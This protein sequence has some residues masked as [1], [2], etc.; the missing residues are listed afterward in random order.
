MS[1]AVH[2]LLVDDERPIL[3]SLQRVFADTE[4]EIH[5]ADSGAAALKLLAEQRVDLILSDMRMPEM[6]GHQFLRQVKEL[7]PQTLRIILSG[8][9]D[10][11]VI[12]RS[13]LDGSAKLYLL[14]PWDNERLLQVV[15]NMLKMRDL[16]RERR[17]LELV[18]GIDTL[19]IVAQTYLAVRRLIDENAEMKEIA[20]EIERDPAMAARVLSLAN[21]AFNGVNTGSV[22]QAI[23]YMGLSVVKELL[24]STSVLAEAPQRGPGFDGKLFCRHAAYANRFVEQIFRRKLAKKLP[25][26]V[27]CAALLCD[28]GTIF[29]T[30]N[31][32]VPYGEAIQRAAGDENLTL[33]QAERELIGVSH[34][35][36]GAYLLE[37]WGLPFSMVEVAMYHHQPQAASEV[38]REVV[39][40]VHV[41]DCL[42]W[43]I[44][45]P[46]RKAEADEWALRQL[47][48]T[49]AE[50]LEMA[51]LLQ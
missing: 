39:C 8:Y 35:E 6:D 46:Q 47:N 37:W 48:L 41:A 34:S 44:M 28:V 33:S 7:Y 24:L 13:L 25:D 51:R 30:R 18:S 19:P 32:A 26:S 1:E 42:A 20:D 14:K 12:F 45:E 22:K 10:E 2:I 29:L 50:C 27:A 9:S 5:I 40:A 3:R 49:A 21:S 38:N 31:F 23:I 11:N 36:L 16:F 15:T 4:Y 17:I 43:Q